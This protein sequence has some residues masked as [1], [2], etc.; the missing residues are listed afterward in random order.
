MGV[1]ISKWLSSLIVLRVSSAAIASTS[2][3]ILTIGFKNGLFSGKKISDYINDKKKDYRNAR[4]C[5]NILDKADT[6][7]EYAKKFELIL[8]KS[9]IK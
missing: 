2:F 7:S 5:I 6:I 9:S 4:R 8:I 3:S 1:L